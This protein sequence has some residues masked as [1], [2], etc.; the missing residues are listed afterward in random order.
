MVSN[1]EI[2][3][4]TEE[5]AQEI[6][7][8]AH[9]ESQNIRHRAIEAAQKAKVQ[10]T[11]DTEKEK[12]QIIKRAEDKAKNEADKIL[13]HSAEE[14]RRLRNQLEANLDKAVTYIIKRIVNG[15]SQS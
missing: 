15:G 1:L 13:S 14:S 2:I 12:A 3:Q 6:V 10:T 9:Q 5:K 7:A 11:I 4:K 8:N